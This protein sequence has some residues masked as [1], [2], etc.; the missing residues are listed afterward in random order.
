MN[1]RD[2]LE[3]ADDLLG[4]LAEAHWRSAVSRAYYAAFHEARRLLRHCGF[5]VPRS[6]KGH[7]HLWLRLSNCGYPDCNMPEPN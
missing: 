6:E 7:E 3:V 4:A 2:L 5:V 1:S